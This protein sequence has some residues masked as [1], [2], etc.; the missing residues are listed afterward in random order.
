ML[1]RGGRYCGDFQVARIEMPAAADFERD[2][3]R[4]GRPVIV[5]GWLGRTAAGRKWSPE[6]LVRAFGEREVV[7]TRLRHGKLRSDNDRYRVRFA[8]YAAAAF[9]GDPAAREFCVQQIGLPKEIARDLPPPPIVATPP[10]SVE[11]KA[12]DQ[13]QRSV[14]ISSAEKSRPPSAS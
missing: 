9:A 8:D 5:T 1:S 7:L 10:T 2:Y 11:S 12:S 4:V 13:S 14:A 6:H 3:A